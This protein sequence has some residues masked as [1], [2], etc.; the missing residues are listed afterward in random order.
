MRTAT[1][2]SDGHW[3]TQ[4]TRHEAGHGAG[5]PVCDDHSVTGAEKATCSGTAQNAEAT[6]R[7]RL[8]D[9]SA[10][11]NNGIFGPASR[12]SKTVQVL[13][14]GVVPMAWINKTLH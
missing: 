11:W 1:T 8:Q 7:K 3:D 12:T 13:G 6:P 2:T 5:D 4:Y 9:N 14:G 10:A